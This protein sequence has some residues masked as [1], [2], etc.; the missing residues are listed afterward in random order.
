MKDK[1]VYIIA[2]GILVLLGFIVVGDFIIALQ[3]SRPVD[4]SI[5][6]L[7]QLTIAGLIGILGTYFG[8]KNNN[9]N[10]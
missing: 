6:N 1:I 4:E 3:E 8:A 7:L 9:Q 10:K 5:V 2:I